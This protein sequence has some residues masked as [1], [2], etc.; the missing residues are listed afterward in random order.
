MLL[1]SFAV[2]A[3]MLAFYLG[4]LAG[5]RFNRGYVGKIVVE[6]KDSGGKR[7][8]LDFGEAD[9]EEIIDKKKSV[10]FEVVRT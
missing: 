5:T 1:F 2:I 7:Y 6:E 8:S 10:S 9:P 4:V 3:I